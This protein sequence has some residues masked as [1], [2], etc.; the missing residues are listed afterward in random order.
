MDNNSIDQYFETFRNEIK[1]NN[2]LSQTD[3]QIVNIA[4]KNFDEWVDTYE[5]VLYEG[6]VKKDQKK[7]IVKSDTAITNPFDMSQSST[8]KAEEKRTLDA[9][10]I[11][12]MTQ[13]IKV[14]FYRSLVTAQM[15]RFSTGKDLR[16]IRRATLRKYNEGKYYTSKSVESLYNAFRRLTAI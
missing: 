7:E 14:T 2:N 9:N 8:E 11:E 12:S 16:T 1:V 15:S 10:E 4:V 3:R 5:Q 6:K 13:L